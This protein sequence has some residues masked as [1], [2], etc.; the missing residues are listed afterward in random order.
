MDIQTYIQRGVELTRI[1][2]LHFFQ[3]DSERKLTLRR[4]FTIL[5]DSL[6]KELKSNGTTLNLDPGECGKEI[7]P[8]GLLT[9]LF[10]MILNAQDEKNRVNVT[11]TGTLSKEKLSLKISDTANRKIP[12][13]NLFE[14]GESDKQKRKIY[15]RYM[16]KHY[17]MGLAISRSIIE[18]LGGTIK[19]HQ[20]SDEQF[21]EIILQKS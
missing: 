10:Q 4:L 14:W 20:N 16:R 15:D 7:V 3:K 21:F 9:V 18:Q 6:D 5:T 13:I 12:D 17:G 2:N 19:L 1:I 8:M 11:I